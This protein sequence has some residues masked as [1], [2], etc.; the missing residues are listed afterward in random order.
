MSVNSKKV[1]QDIIGRVSANQIK[2]E[3]DIL[4]K[5]QKKLNIQE[6]LL[7]VLRGVSLGMI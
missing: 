5:E 6:T 1:R 2:A 3:S 7:L 4:E